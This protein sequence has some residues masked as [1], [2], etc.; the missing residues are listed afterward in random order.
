[1]KDFIL[2]FSVFALI[3]IGTGCTLNNEE[4]YFTEQFCDTTNVTYQ[5]VRSIFVNNCATCHNFSSTYR[6][7]I[8]LDTYESTVS[9]IETGLV[10]PAIKHTGPYQM[11]YEQPQ[12]PDCFIRQIEMWI[13]NDMPETTEDL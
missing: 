9:S 2:V 5:M 4:E 3:Y 1:M 11:P 12:L 10:I 6:E 7:G 13:E 8:E